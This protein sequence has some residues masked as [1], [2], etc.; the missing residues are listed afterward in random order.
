MGSFEI[1]LVLPIAQFG[2]ERT[3]PRWTDARDG[4]LSEETGLRHDLDR[5]CASLAGGRRVAARGVGRYLDH[6]R[7]R[8]RDLPHQ[9]GSWVLLPSIATRASLP[10]LRKPLMRSAA[11]DSS[12]GWGRVTNGRAEA[13]AFGLP[14]RQIIARFE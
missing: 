13:H 2:P 1:G 7:G 12:S 9:V 3:T 6:G 11:A 14:E 10:R 5:R 8:R 4:R